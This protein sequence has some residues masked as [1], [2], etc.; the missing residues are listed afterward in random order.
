MICAKIISLN[1]LCS[2]SRVFVSFGGL[3]VK[4]IHCGTSFVWKV[5]AS[6]SSC[7]R[8]VFG[9]GELGRELPDDECPLSI[10][11]GTRFGFAV[12]GT[13]LVVGLLGLLVEG[14]RSILGFRLPST[15]I[16]SS[17][18]PPWPL[19]LGIPSETTHMISDSCFNPS[20]LAETPSSFRIRPLYSS[21][22]RRGSFVPVCFDACFLTSPIR[23]RPSLIA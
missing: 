19:P 22:I 17:E 6:W 16:S 11:G 2:K 7:P 4:R 14:R 18:L 12:G 20:D 23:S 1:F 8:A 5:E 15:S 3:E 21:L 10:G 13:S 9:A